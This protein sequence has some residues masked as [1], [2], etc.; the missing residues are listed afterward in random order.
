MKSQRVAFIVPF[1]GT[2][3]VV[4]WFA[5]TNSMLSAL[6]AGA[7]GIMLHWFWS[8][9]S[10]SADGEL[11]DA[12]YF[13]G[14]LL[15]LIFLA[16]GLFTLGDGKGTG[17]DVHEFLRD[18]A[19]GLALTVV[20]L[21]VRQI[22]VLGPVAAQRSS[23]DIPLESRGAVDSSLGESVRELVA[24]LRVQSGTD[25]HQEI[26][27]SRQRARAAAAAL[28]QSLVAAAER[29]GRAMSLFEGTM[30]AATG[31]VFRAGNSL[32]EGVTQASGRMNSAASEML[33]AVRRQRTA[34]DNALSQSL[35]ATAS[36][37]EALRRYAEGGEQFAVLAN[38]VA[39]RIETLPDPS[40]RLSTLWQSV[41][42]LEQRLVD[43]ITR[44]TTAIDALNARTTEA[45][46]GVRAL[47]QATH[48]AADRLSTAAGAVAESLRR[49]LKALDQLIDEFVKVL[50]RRVE[51]YAE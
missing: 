16:A 41:Q 40:E 42:A 31:S 13:F 38:Q 5:S 33:E 6:L 43:S 7:A 39:E 34:A 30:E 9:H 44:M 15:T 17:A 37:H 47:G 10:D 21:V 49:E 46:T 51:A 18:L 23:A 20:G 3:G 45:S 32:S 22:R 2:A 29:I 12:S 24:V 14:F 50:E 8:A 48:T 19:A 27:E 4:A 25:V 1:I 11:A 36:L 26:D 28:D 35:A